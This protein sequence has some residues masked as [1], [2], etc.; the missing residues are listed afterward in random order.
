MSQ[1][2]DLG[3][4][5]GPQ[6]PTGAT[7]PQG[8]QGP[9]GETGPQGP[10]G[11]KGDTGEQGPAGAGP[12]N[13]VNGDGTL[14]VKM[15]H[16]AV[17]STSRYTNSADGTLAAA[18]GGYGE[19]SHADGDFSLTYGYSCSALSKGSIAG[20]D[21]CTADALNNQPGAVAL[22]MGSRAAEYVQM[23]MGKYNKT[24]VSSAALLAIG[25]GTGD[26]ARSNA[27][28]IKD[29]GSVYAQK[30]FN[31]N[32]ADYAEW[33]EWA[34]GNPSDEDRVGY[35]VTLEGNKI[36][37]AGAEDD[38]LGIVSGTAGVV[39]DSHEEDWHRRFM[40][41][42]FGRLLRQT[43]EIPAQEDE[44]GCEIIPGYTTEWF[45]VNP[46]W[47]AEEAYVP[48]SE[49]SEWDI[50]GLMGK[51][52]VRDDGTAAA[53]GYVKP[54]DG[55]IATAAEERTRWRVLERTGDNIVR[56]MMRG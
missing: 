18:F 36:R 24:G 27:M 14:S 54:S 2:F 48:R 52:Y 32:G 11:P 47:D 10:Q 29:D 43:V 8:P 30:N 44:N 33:F 37:Q 22:G 45:V 25:N 55:G 26:S 6:G 15:N 7:G 12:S 35:F 38:V 50:V 17:P 1:E 34:D 28:R 42:A 5:M 21:L 20:G 9:Q 46:E 51:L 53:G 41:D 4:V 40:T 49:R 19:G 56:V 13:L 39:G 16:V 3:N 23:A 31:P